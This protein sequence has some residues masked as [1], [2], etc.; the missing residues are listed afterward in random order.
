MPAPPPTPAEPP[1]YFEQPTPQAAPP[2]KKLSRRASV[3]GTVL[4]LVV[5]AGLAWLAW[6]LTR[7]DTGTAAKAGTGAGGGRAGAGAGGP[8]G[9]G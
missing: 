2:R 6:D 1:E 4:A 8:G 7:P 3:I 9:P 5:A